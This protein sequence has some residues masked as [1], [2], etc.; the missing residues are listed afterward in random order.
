MDSFCDS[1]N[2][3]KCLLTASTIT[4]LH[5]YYVIAGLILYTN[6]SFLCLADGQ[7]TYSVGLNIDSSWYS[8]YDIN[9]I[10]KMMIPL[11]FIIPTKRI[12]FIH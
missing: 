2:S 12:V 5:V 1:E 9:I 11:S 3:G 10:G 6:N 4:F 8:I 7:E